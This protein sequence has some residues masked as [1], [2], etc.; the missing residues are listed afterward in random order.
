M[1]TPATE[2]AAVPEEIGWEA[3]KEALIAFEGVLRANDVGLD[4]FGRLELLDL[5]LRRLQE[6]W[7]R[8]LDET[9]P[10]DN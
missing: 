9:E 8:H 3:L 4:Y 10:Q 6:R 7:D 1:R 2:A 5:M